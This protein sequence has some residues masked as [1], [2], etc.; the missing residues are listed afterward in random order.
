MNGISFI[1][2]CFLIYVLSVILPLSCS[3]LS[4]FTL[5]FF[6]HPA[7]AIVPE[8]GIL[9]ACVLVFF[10]VLR[11]CWKDDQQNEKAQLQQE[12]KK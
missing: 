3:H 9:F 12:E 11:A 10:A 1:W 5:D 7:D 6:S 2:L 4:I 8:L